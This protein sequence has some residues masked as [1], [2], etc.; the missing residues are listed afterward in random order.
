ME[1]K[2]P[3]SFLSYGSCFENSISEGKWVEGGEEKKKKKKWRRRSSSSRRRAL[4]LCSARLMPTVEAAES[5]WEM[6]ACISRG[7]KENM[8]R[9]SRWKD[10][11]VGT[12]RGAQKGKL[13]LGNNIKYIFTL[14]PRWILSNFILCLQCHRGITLSLAKLSAAGDVVSPQWEGNC[15]INL[16]SDSLY[17]ALRA[18]TGAQHWMQRLQFNKNPPWKLTLYLFDP[19]SCYFCI[20]SGGIDCVSPPILRGTHRIEILYFLRNGDLWLY[21]FMSWCSYQIHIWT[22][23]CTK[24]SCTVYKTVQ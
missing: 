17:L 5:L 7:I 9:K 4:K 16:I 15:W 21:S 24:P 6:S 18:R 10:K 11:C 2:D 20:K 8:Q 19:F 23:Q 22:D 14:N 12:L 3:S 13:S 1:N